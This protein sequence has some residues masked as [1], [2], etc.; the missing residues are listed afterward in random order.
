MPGLPSKHFA[1]IYIFITQNSLEIYYNCLLFTDK[2]AEV[3]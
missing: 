3:E 1:C 2:K